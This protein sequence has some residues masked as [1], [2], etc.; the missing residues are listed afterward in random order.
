[1]IPRLLPLGALLSVPICAS[2]SA[3]GIPTA[4]IRSASLSAS[5]AK[6]ESSAPTSPP[7]VSRSESNGQDTQ[8]DS[9]AGKER[10]LDLARRG[11]VDSARRAALAGLAS[12]PDDPFL[13]LLSGKLS[14]PGRESAEYLGKALQAG[15]TPEAEEALFRLGQ[16]TYATGKYHLAIPRFREYIRA[17]PHGAWRE[18]ALYWMGNGCLA[19]ARSRTDKDDYLDSAENWFRLLKDGTAE[20]AYYH[21]LAWEGLAKSKAFKGDREGAWQA[22]RTALEKAPAEEQPPLLLLAAQTRQGIDRAGE[23]SLLVRLWENYP[24]SPE[25]RYLRR[26]NGG[27]SDPKRWKSGPGLPRNVGPAAREGAVPIE[28]GITAG[29]AHPPPPSEGKAD[30][31]NP[32]RPEE[33]PYTLQC[34]AFAQA[35]NAQAMEKSL[36][37]LG[38]EPEVLAGEL[39][40]KRIYQVRVGRFATAEEAEAFAQAKLKPHRILSRPVAVADDS[41]SD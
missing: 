1:V 35:A 9:G 2:L 27:A 17:Y 11:L 19:F 32:T 33:K 38:F 36:R 25:A 10:L 15:G 3:P 30:E 39:A 23:E 28:G 6:P 20:D 41:V 16:Y 14:V 22:A 26:I 4:A 37:G 29:P 24:H 7:P 13:L 8:A 21:T 31:Q 12:R 40:G 18:P 5:A 34:G